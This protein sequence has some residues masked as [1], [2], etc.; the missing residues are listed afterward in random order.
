MAEE[1]EGRKKKEADEEVNEYDDSLPTTPKNTP[2]AKVIGSSF[3]DKDVGGELSGDGLSTAVS[4]SSSHMPQTTTGE[5]QLTEANNNNNNNHQDSSNIAGNDA[6]G[7]KVVKEPSKP[8]KNDPDHPGGS[9]EVPGANEDSDRIAKLIMGSLDERTN[10]STINSIFVTLDTHHKLHIAHSRSWRNGRVGLV[11]KQDAEGKPV[12]DAEGKPVTYKEGEHPSAYTTISHNDVKNGVWKPADH[13][14][15]KWCVEY[16]R[17]LEVSGK[18]QLQIWP[19]HCLI[20][21]V[22]HSVV[23]CIA[24][25]L[26]A[27]SKTTRKSVEYVKVGQNI[28]TEAY[29]VF[30]AEVGL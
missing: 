4:E 1:E 3:S 27:W 7:P 19:E 14:D 15:E 21:T 6:E 10:T 17:S 9:L 12:T 11:V 16:T 26:R 5:S 18:F 30:K 13:L 2:K 29:S 28:R 24:N 8:N 23:P 25:A 20:G 22:G